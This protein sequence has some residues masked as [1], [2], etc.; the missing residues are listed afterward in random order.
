VCCGQLLVLP[1][2]KWAPRAHFKTARN[3]V[4]EW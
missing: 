1:H 4:R 2:K 3:V